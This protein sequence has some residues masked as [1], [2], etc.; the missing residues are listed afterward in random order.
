MNP[1]ISDERRLEVRGNKYKEEVK[2][3]RQEKLMKALQFGD[4]FE[5]VLKI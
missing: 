2:R 1:C 4:Q 5:R 3:L